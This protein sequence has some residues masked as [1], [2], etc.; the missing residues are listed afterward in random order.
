MLAYGRIYAEL[1]ALVDEFERLGLRSFLFNDTLATSLRDQSDRHPR[2]AWA[3][4]MLG[5]HTA[6]L[7][8]IDALLVEVATKRFEETLASLEELNHARQ[9]LGVGR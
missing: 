3:A 5:M 2:G 4:E 1:A 6:T 8:F 9:K 7:G